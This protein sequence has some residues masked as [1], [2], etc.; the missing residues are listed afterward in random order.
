MTIPGPIHK[1]A[2]GPS[3][4]VGRAQL[5]NHKGGDAENTSKSAAADD[6][7]MHN[8]RSRRSCIQA[9]AWAVRKKD[10]NGRIV[11]G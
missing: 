5:P 7:S 9:G 8:Y 3:K 10:M 4:S 1:H 6:S 11:A 2:I